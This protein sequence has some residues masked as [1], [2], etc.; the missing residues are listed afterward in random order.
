MLFYEYFLKKLNQKITVVLKNNLRISGDLVNVDP[1]INLKIKNIQ[2]H[3]DCIGLNDM[4]IC[5]IRGYSIRYVVLEKDKLLKKLNE[6][7]RLCL[8]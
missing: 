2:L 7:T 8:Y 6:G 3:S 1:Y 4:E 5:S